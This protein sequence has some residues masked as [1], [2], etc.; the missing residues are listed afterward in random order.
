MLKVL[1]SILLL[2]IGLF[3]ANCVDAG[4]CPVNCP[5]TAG[6]TTFAA[7]PNTAYTTPGGTSI[8]STDCIAFICIDTANSCSATACQSLTPI[9]TCAQAYMPHGA[10]PNTLFW[11]LGWHGGGGFSG[12]GAEAFGT[13]GG[14]S[15]YPIKL[16]ETYRDTPNPVGGTG[17]GIVEFDYAW[18]PT[19]PACPSCTGLY[20]VQPQAAACGVS[21]V[22]AGISGL[23]SGGPATLGYYGPSW[24]GIMVA[25]ATVPS[26]AYGGPSGTC[27]PSD[28]RPANYRAVEAWPPYSWCQPHNNSSYTNSVGAAPQTAYNG[29]FGTSTYA[30]C[31]TADAAANSGVGASP[32]LSLSSTNASQLLTGKNF[33]QFGATDTTVEPYWAGGGTAVVAVSGYQ[34]IGTTPVM[35]VYP[36]CAHECDLDSIATGGTKGDAFNFLLNV[37]IGTSSGISGTL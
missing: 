12:Y 15:R 3:A 27:I 35:T 24:G 4:T 20:P 21:Y 14:L 33:L 13:S 1:L 7:I 5:T 34:G 30:G 2:P 29:Q 32:Y 11:V 23:L 25:F 19:S 17:I 28:A 18:S 37:G 10:N 16:I 26:S 31:Y 9:V 22:M 36:N 6:S 8:A